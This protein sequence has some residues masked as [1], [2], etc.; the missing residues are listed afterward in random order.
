MLELLAARSRELA[1]ARSVRKL[2]LPLPV[3]PDM[4]PFGLLLG[5]DCAFMSGCVGK[6]RKYFIVTVHVL[7]QERRV[8]ELGIRLLSSLRSRS[9]GIFADDCNGVDGTVKVR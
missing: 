5:W 6:L 1:A 2:I 8:G 4:G 9:C 7:A 3:V